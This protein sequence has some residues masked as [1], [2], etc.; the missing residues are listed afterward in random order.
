MN[1]M[2]VARVAALALRTGILVAGPLLMAGMITGVV[3]GLLQAM[4][5]VNEATVTIVPKMAAVI[6]A[7]ALGGP[8]IFQTLRQ[9][10]EGLYQMIPSVTG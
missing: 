4:T 8:W 2:D 6:A 1:A 7:L 5:Q 3:F 9:L 10:I